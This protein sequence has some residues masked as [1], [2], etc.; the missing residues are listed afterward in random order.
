[1]WAVSACQFT[2]ESGE[3]QFEPCP[4]LTPSPRLWGRKDRDVGY[5]GVTLRKVMGGVVRGKQPLAL[6]GA[7]GHWRGGGRKQ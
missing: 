4:F 7:T 3:D 2:A 6:Q 1:M 5:G